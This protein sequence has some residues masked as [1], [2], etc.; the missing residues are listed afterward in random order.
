MRAVAL[1][2]MH[3]LFETQDDDAEAE[4]E[5]VGLG[6]I[7]A[8]LVDWTDP[9]KCYVPGNELVLSSSSAA[10]E[11]AKKAVNGDVHLDFA[12]DILERLNGSM[13]RMFFP[14]LALTSRIILKLT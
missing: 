8:H 2:A 11:Q 7:G 6:T 5:M 3:K 1:D 14:F 4:A 13:R 12:M 9:R 10:D